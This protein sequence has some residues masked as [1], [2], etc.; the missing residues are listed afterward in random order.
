[1]PWRIRE[2]GD[3]FCVV[4]IEPDDTDGDTVKCYADY[5]DALTLLRALYANIDDAAAEKTLAAIMA[6]WKNRLMWAVHI[7]E[8]DLELE[9]LENE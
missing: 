7:L 1:M 4:K 5:Q 9:E 8:L 6:V 2:R 3:E